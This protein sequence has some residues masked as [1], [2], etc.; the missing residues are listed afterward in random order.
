MRSAN[1]LDSHEATTADGGFLARAI[2]DARG[3]R[4]RATIARHVARLARERA[5]EM[6]R[7][8]ASRDQ[9][10]RMRRAQLRLIAFV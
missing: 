7:Q 9:C 6:R 10:S 2:G 8:A 4:Q 1:R 5:Q 3:A